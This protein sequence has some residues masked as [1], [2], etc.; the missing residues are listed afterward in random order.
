MGTYVQ[1][2]CPWAPKEK[3]LLPFNAIQITRPQTP[4]QHF[5]GT[6]MLICILDL[7]ALFY[8][9][10]HFLFMLPNDKFSL[11]LSED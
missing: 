5:S 6:R 10:I 4:C 8:S 11:C 2:A 3:R 9:F 7:N 1:R